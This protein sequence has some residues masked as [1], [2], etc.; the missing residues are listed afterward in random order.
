MN[1]LIRESW[2]ASQQGADASGLLSV[3]LS[4]EA[5]SESVCSC[6]SG[7][8]APEMQSLVGL[9]GRLGERLGMLQ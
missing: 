2:W 7:P 6:W 5:E 1:I 3:S 4:Q 9:L 8:V